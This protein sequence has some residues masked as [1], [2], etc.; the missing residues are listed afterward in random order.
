MNVS[1][2]G[3]AAGRKY[4]VESLGKQTTKFDDGGFAELQNLQ[5]FFYFMFCFWKPLFCFYIFTFTLLS[6]SS[7]SARFVSAA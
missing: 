4:G 3:G 7:Y 6:E 5:V 1:P 2:S